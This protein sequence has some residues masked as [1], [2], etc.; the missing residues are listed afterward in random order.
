VLLDHRHG[1]PAVLR[2]PLY[3]DAVGQ[4]H[5]N[6]RV[7]HRVRFSD[8]T[9]LALRARYQIFARQVWKS[10]GSPSWFKNTGESSHRLN[11]LPRAPSDYVKSES[12]FVSCEPE[13]KGLAHT[14]AVLGEDRIIFASDYPHGDC[15]FPHSVTKIRNRGDLP[16]SLK[17]KILW[18]NPA[19]L[20][21]IS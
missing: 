13:E 19:R 7:A 4:A 20:D 8:P 21:G 14:A 11:H 12:C 16:E 10:T 6:K 3:L 15:D 17:E 5:R 1:G 18:K 2:Q 9:S